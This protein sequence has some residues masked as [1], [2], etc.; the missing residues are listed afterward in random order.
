MIKDC[1]NFDYK[2]RPSFTEIVDTIKKNNFSLIDGLDDQIEALKDR[3]A[4]T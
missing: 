1:C 2:K 4:L 3:L